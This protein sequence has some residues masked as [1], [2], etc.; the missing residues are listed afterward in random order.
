MIPINHILI[1]S[2]PGLVRR[3]LA[4]LLGLGDRSGGR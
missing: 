4:A 2:E 1:L 3:Q